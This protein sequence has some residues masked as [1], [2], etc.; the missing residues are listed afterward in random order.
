MLVLLLYHDQSL[1]FEFECNSMLELGRQ[2]PE[3]ND[4]ELFSTQLLARG[5]RLVIAPKEDKSIPRNLLRLESLS[6]GQVRITNMSKYSLE[7]ILPELITLLPNDSKEVKI[8]LLVSYGSVAIQLESASHDSQLTPLKTNLSHPYIPGDKAASIV[9]QILDPK[10]V[11][12]KTLISWLQRMVM[13]LHGAAGSNEFYHSAAQGIVDL[14]GLDTGRVLLWKDNR[15]GTLAVA[16]SAEI[17]SKPTPSNM[18]LNSILLEKKTFR[19]LPNYRRSGSLEGVSAIVASPLLDGKGEVIG[20]LYGDRRGAIGTTISEAEAMLVEVLASSVSVGLARMDQERDAIAAR[21]RFEEF[22]TPNLARQLEDD[23]SLLNPREAEVTILF[24]DVRGFSRISENLTPDIT[25]AWINEVLE[26]LSQ[27]VLRHEGV[28][29]DYVGDELEA[30][31]G[32]P[33]KQKD[34]A[35]RACHC[36]LEMLR[37][38]PN[39]NHRWKARLGTEFSISIGIN[40]GPVQVG[41]KG[42][43]CKFSYGPLG[44]TVNLASR[45]QGATRY[46]KTPLLITGS[47]KAYLGS[48]IPSRRLCRVE[49]VNKKNPV[50]LYGIYEPDQFQEELQKR[51]EQAL[52]D[53]EKGDYRSATRLLGTLYPQFEDPP[54]LVLLQR[55]ITGMV[56]GKAEEVWKL[57]G[58]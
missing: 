50:D 44:D 7:L 57:P 23:P 22:F 43:K 4:Q 58:K 37:V 41:N 19:E 38:V 47:T 46:L 16:S 3:R 2:D 1:Q 30:M 33:Q 17:V 11:D 29:V 28:L 15:W 26:E 35:R 54:T 48:S 25:L 21:V 34:H 51:Y 27:C 45:V 13:V 31:W 42:S 12:A 9:A 40:T 32:A 10:P 18:I 55:A 52:I 36:A 39:L 14:I 24:C 49:V 53:F 20:A 5:T 56:D 8:P 6:N